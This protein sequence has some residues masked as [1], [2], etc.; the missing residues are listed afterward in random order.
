MARIGHP[1]GP[2]AGGGQSPRCGS[3]RSQPSR[4]IAAA[5]WLAYDGPIPT[6]FSIARPRMP[7]LS[8]QYV[9]QGPA[10]TLVQFLAR[11]FRYHTAEEW[12]DL[13]RKG[14]VKV[15]GARSKPGSVLLTRHKIVYERPPFPEPEVDRNY[16]I[17]YEDGHLL[18]VAKSGNMPTSPSGK[19]W[20]NCLVHVLQQERGLPELHAVH[21]LDRET[22]GVNLF[23]K[24]KAIARAMGDDFRAGRVAK[25]YA[26]I[27][28]GRFPARS[29]FVSAPLGQEVASTIRIK[30]AVLA[31]GRPCQTEFELRALLPGASLLLVTPHTGRTH[32]I[33]AHA[34]YLGHPVWGDKLYGVP[35][36]EGALS[37][38]AASAARHAPCVHPPANRRRADRAGQSRAA[39][40]AV[41]RSGPGLMRRAPR[42]WIKLARGAGRRRGCWHRCDSRCDAPHRS[43]ADSRCIGAPRAADTAPQTW[44]RRA[45]SAESQRVCA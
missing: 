13:V 35:E 34:A 42:P 12:Q 1:R 37:A 28:R 31:Q 43:V 45:R 5:A 30:Q 19:Y 18:A 14:F 39:A 23:A 3:S 26:A 9:R 41:L 16:R 27:V 22:S 21:R 38:V 8:F 44:R 2:A 7:K 20:Q 40:A 17:L 25:T 10:E 15:N 24:S 29:V 11:R 4:T 36:A 6:G 32:Q 33:R